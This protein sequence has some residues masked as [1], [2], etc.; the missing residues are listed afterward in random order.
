MT[1]F[2]QWMHGARPRTLPL[3]VAPIIAAAAVVPGTDRDGLVLS[4]CAA[5][6]LALQVGVNYANDYSDGVRGTDARRAVTGGPVRLVGQG[7]A[8]PRAVKRAAYLSFLLACCVGLIV[9]AAAGDWRLLLIGAAAVPAAWFY[10]GGSRPYGYAGFGEVFV[11]AFFGLAAVLGTVLAASGR[12]TSSS[13]W[14]AIGEGLLASAVLMVNNVRDIATDAPQGKHTLAV[15][16]GDR[17]SRYAYALMV[18]VGMLAM[19]L[20]FVPAVTPAAAWLLASLALVCVVWLGRRALSDI[21]GPALVRLLA[22]TSRCALLV[23]V[24]ALVLVLVASR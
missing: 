6:A 18:T 11:F 13:W 10:T 23:S 3:A 8:S 21:H 22:A 20:G 16:L 17:R 15:R 1:T 24:V 5:V 14:V 19:V 12:L 9:V 4:G 7:L 2:A